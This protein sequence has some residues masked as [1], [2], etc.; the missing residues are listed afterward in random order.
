MV[1]NPDPRLG[2]PEQPRP[3]ALVA[4]V[5]ATARRVHG[6]SRGELERRHHWPGVHCARAPCHG[7]ELRGTW[8]DRTAST[9]LGGAGRTDRQQTSAR[10]SA[11]P[12]HRFLA[13][14]RSIP[15]SIGNAS[16]TS[17]EP[18]SRKV[19][20]SAQAGRSSAERPSSPRTH[21][22]SPSITTAPPP[23]PS[24]PRTKRSAPCFEEPT[25]SSW[26]TI[27]KPPCGYGEGIALSVSPL[28]LSRHRCLA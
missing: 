7:S 8:L 15:P 27:A 3:P 2:D 20:I 12:S 13:G 6:V 25:G 21:T 24:M 22:T 26:L 1:R 17:C 11:S 5:P 10:R 23:P 16:S 19:G 9:K 18:Q 4:P 14:R 28:G